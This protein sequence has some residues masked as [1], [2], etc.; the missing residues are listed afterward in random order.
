MIMVVRMG[1][2]AVERMTEEINKLY[3]SGRVFSHWIIYYKIGCLEATDFIV[4]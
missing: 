1:E 2:I 3:Y 4:D